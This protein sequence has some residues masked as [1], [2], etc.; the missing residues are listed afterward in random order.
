[1]RCPSAGNVLL[2]M[3][4]GLEQIGRTGRYFRQ[5]QIKQSQ[6][7]GSSPARRSRQYLLHTA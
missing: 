6:L 1:M 2:L 3:Y 7:Y 5:R 4:G